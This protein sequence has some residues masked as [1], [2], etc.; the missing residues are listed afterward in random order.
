MSFGHG[1]DDDIRL[2]RFRL[3]CSARSPSFPPWQGGMNALPRYAIPESALDVDNMDF[4]SVCKWRSAQP[5]RRMA[6]R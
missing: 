5:S 3:L 1:G 6:C 4:H 2:E